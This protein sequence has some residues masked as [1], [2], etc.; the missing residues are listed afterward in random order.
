MSEQQRSAKQESPEPS[1][2]MS[3]AVVCLIQRS[4]DSQGAG[5]RGGAG[6]IEA[7][8]AAVPHRRANALPNWVMGARPRARIAGAITKTDTPSASTAAISKC[9]A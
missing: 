3:V 2:G 5:R 4:A 1:L 9:S 8:L 7:A 6:T